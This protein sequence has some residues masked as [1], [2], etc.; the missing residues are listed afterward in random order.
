MS[1]AYAHTRYIIHAWSAVTYIATA[2][3][4]GRSYSLND[5]NSVDI[6]MDVELFPILLK[7]VISD[8]EQKCTVIFLTAYVHFAPFKPPI[9]L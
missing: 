4:K 6:F 5:P 8:G 9:K 3:A 2:L 7:Y 1:N